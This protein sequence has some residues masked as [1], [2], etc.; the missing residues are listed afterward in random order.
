MKASPAVEPSPH[1][2]APTEGV[3]SSDTTMIE[4]A[5]RPGMHTPLMRPKSMRLAPEAACGSP[6]VKPAAMRP[7]PEVIA[8]NES[9][10][11]RDV[12]IVVVN[13]CMVVPVGSPVMPAPA[14]ATEE[15]NSEANTE[16]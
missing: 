2:R 5:E 7:G 16:R 14:I 6:A 13:D 12:G 11:V 10:A 1:A 15:P 4:S 9:A 3:S 8:I